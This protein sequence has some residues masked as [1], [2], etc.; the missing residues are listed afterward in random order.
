MFID[1]SVLHDNI[2]DVIE[3]LGSYGGIFGI[4]VDIGLV[5]V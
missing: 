5:V 2:L 3:R 1:I 4:M